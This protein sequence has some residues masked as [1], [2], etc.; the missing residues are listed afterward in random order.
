V[1]HRY[2]KKYDDGAKEIQDKLAALKEHASAIRV[3]MHTQP[4]KV[5]LGARKA[6]MMEIQVNGGTVAEKVDF[7]YGLFEKEVC[8]STA[9]KAVSFPVEA[10]ARRA[11]TAACLTEWARSLCHATQRRC[12]GQ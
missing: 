1:L 12:V 7:A 4:R 5:N 2:A 9:A 11:G 6:H 8:S 3:L 10:M